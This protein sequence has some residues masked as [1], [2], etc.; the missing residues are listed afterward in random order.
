MNEKLNAISTAAAAVC[1]ATDMAEAVHASGKYKVQCHAYEGGPLLWEEEIDNLVTTGGKTRVSRAPGSQRRG[2]R[3]L[4][5]AG[6]H[7]RAAR[8]GGR[9]ARVHRR[10]DRSHPHQA[11][12]P[13][14][15]RTARGLDADRLR[16]RAAPGLPPERD[17]SADEQHR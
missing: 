16:D 17:E 14:A 13:H 1:A 10:A 5:R 11:G 4:H 3:L 8:P 2:A 6:R 7:Q 15:T 9:E 12:R